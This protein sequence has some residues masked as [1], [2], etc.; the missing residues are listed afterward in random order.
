MAAYDQN[1]RIEPGRLANL[2][3]NYQIKRC[4]RKR[5]SGRMSDEGEFLLAYGILS[6]YHD[7]LDKYDFSLV[8]IDRLQSK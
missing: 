7:S 8:F 5:L 4:H 1:A 2:K 3:T 6:K